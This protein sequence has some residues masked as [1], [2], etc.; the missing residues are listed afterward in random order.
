MLRLVATIIVA[1]FLAGVLTGARVSYVSHQRNRELVGQYQP[2]VLCDCLD[3]YLGLSSPGLI[4]K[5]QLLRCQVGNAVRAGH[6][7]LASALADKALSICN[8]IDPRCP[9]LLMQEGF[10]A[11]LVSLG[12]Y[13]D[14]KRIIQSLPAV[15][16]MPVEKGNPAPFIA[17]RQRILGESLLGLGDFTGSINELQRP[18]NGL[19][20][21]SPARW[22]LQVALAQAYLAAGKDDLAHNAFVQLRGVSTSSEFTDIYLALPQSHNDPKAYQAVL[23]FC[24]KFEQKSIP[25]LETAIAYFRRD[26]NLKAASELC[27]IVDC[28][29][30]Q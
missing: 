23:S 15:Q 1:L 30:K 25:N 12:R 28:L 7:Q 19:A 20:A 26:G 6:Y 4:Q 17:Y 3:E 16:E 13:E 8:H 21:D 2:N 29:K 24:L 9:D 10:A 14:A 5:Y 27:A 22:D 18:V 11:D